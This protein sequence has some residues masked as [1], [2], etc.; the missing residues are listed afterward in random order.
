MWQKAKGDN[1]VLLTKVNEINSAMGPVAVE[2]QHAIFSDLSFCTVI[3]E[4]LQ[5]M[6]AE[7]DI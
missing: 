4:M 7:L 6:Q 3:L 1:L 2:H 5:P